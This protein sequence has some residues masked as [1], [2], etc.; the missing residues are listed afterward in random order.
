MRLTLITDSF[1]PHAGGS[2]YYYYNLFRRMADRHHDRVTVITKKVEGWATFDRENCTAD[3]RIRR[4]FKPL[5]NLGY[6]ELPKAAGSIFHSAAYLP[7]SDVIHCGDLYP[8]G[9]AALLA[10]ALL[11]K[12]FIAYCHGEDIT[13]T[14][15]RQFQPRYR[16]Y[17]YRQADAVVANGDF[18]IENLLRTGIPRS[19][20]VK[21]TPGLDANRFYP[22]DPSQELVS[23][24]RLAGKTV[25]LT[26][27][28]LVPRKGQDLVLKAL[29]KLRRDVPNLRYLIVGKG[30]DEQR[31][32]TIAREA[33]VEDLVEFVGFVPD[34]MVNQYY[35]LADIVVMPN[36]D[37]MGDVEG[38]GMVF[39]EANAA[40]KPVI[41]GR[42]GGAGE[43]IMDGET[44][45]LVDSTS[46]E[47]ILAGMKA[48]AMNKALQ[49]RFGAAGRLRVT[50]D[51]DWDSRADLLHKISAEL[52]DQIL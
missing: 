31:L 16:D 24:H 32:H 26:I 4:M 19:K 46:E 14:D 48:L 11:R 8:P 33:A 6:T 22:G 51:F 1:L 40:G 43:A 47:A 52:T 3:F 21:I 29:A 20:I 34:E 9:L 49:E 50:R 30:P 41:A 38:F 45:L 36:R 27:A 35:N 37:S 42:S 5:A 39:L 25:L 44:G 12:P 28:R 2:R 18:A 10:K 15:R 7:A 23:K 17:V 13:L